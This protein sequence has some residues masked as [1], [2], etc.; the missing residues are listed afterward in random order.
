MKILIILG[1]ILTLHNL[2]MI[3]AGYLLV[4]GTMVNLTFK[5]RLEKNIIAMGDSGAGKSESLE[6]F[7]KLSESYIKEMKIIFDDMGVLK[8]NENTLT[9]SGTEIGAFIQL[10]DL[11]IRYLTKKLIEVFL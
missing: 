9:A 3:D 5:N 7:K 11:D 2:K 1:I 8:L 4:H 6:A 10:D